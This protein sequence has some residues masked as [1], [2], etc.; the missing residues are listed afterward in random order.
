[1]CPPDGRPRVHFELTR[2]FSIPAGAL[3]FV[4]N[5]VAIPNGFSK[6]WQMDSRSTPAASRKISFRQ[7]DWTGAILFLASAIL[8]VTAFQEAVTVYAFKSATIITMLVLSMIALGFLTVWEY[9]LAHRRSQ[10]V[11][12]ITWHFVTRRGLGLFM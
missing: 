3:A 9:S 2:V 11:P 5:A 1:M 4:L 10:I 8:L 6:E 7:L 12:I